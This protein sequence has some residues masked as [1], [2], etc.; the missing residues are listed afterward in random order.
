MT[1]NLNL[2]QLNRCSD[3]DLA[4]LASQRASREYL[5]YRQRTRGENDRV[6]AA[7]RQPVTEPLPSLAEARA[8]EITFG[9]YRGRTV[10]E[11]AA[12]EAG[13]EYLAYLQSWGPDFEQDEIRVASRAVQPLV[14]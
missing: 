8:T 13:R 11:L 7:L 2:Y 10:G 14:W 1:A 6:T 12:T 3:A 9:Q 4:H 5:I